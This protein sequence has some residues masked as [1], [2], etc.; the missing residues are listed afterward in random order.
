MFQKMNIQSPLKTAN[1]PQIRHNFCGLPYFCKIDGSFR[2]LFSYVRIVKIYSK[3]L[4]AYA[5]TL[6]FS[7]K[8]LK[9]PQKRLSWDICELSSNL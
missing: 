1:N 6:E 3:S 8:L 4:Y 7:N 5:N 9:F 2:I